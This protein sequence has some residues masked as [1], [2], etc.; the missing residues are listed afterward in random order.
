M[1]NKIFISINSPLPQ[2]EN[3]QD[4][5]HTF[6][7]N[8]RVLSNSCKRLKGLKQEGLDRDL[9]FLPKKLI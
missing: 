3:L 1:N 7:N 9:F 5:F 8:E 6:F 4:I 2:L